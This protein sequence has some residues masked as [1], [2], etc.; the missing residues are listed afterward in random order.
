MTEGRDENV[1]VVPGPPEG[2]AVAP[3][4]STDPGPV[5][6]PTPE[7]PPVKRAPS[8]IAHTIEEIPPADAAE[9]LGNLEPREAA[10]VA[11]FLD[12]ETAAGVLAQME[13]RDAA[14]VIS[15]MEPPEAAMVLTEMNPDD[16]VD[17][18]E[19][20]EDPTRREALLNEMGAAEAADVRTLGQFPPDTAGGIMTTD[21]TALPQDLNAQ[22][23]IDELRRL[24][25]TLEQMFYVYVIDRA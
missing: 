13:S 18:L 8:Y 25:E 10:S 11:E 2:V 20:I 19:R 16:A 3:A 22:Q 6:Q 15:E 9:L 14:A 4:T 17:V 1:H 24:N 12:P 5:A 21:I 23:A 7:A